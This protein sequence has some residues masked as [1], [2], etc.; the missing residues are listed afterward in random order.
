M[1]LAGVG[2]KTVRGKREREPA[3]LTQAQARTQIRAWQPNAARTSTEG[4]VNSRLGVALHLLRSTDW[5][6]S[7]SNPHL[8]YYV[9]LA[10]HSV[11]EVSALKQ[12]IRT[13][14]WCGTGEVDLTKKASH[15]RVRGN[16]KRDVSLEVAC[17][18]LCCNRLHT[19]AATCTSQDV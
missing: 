18:A 10:K 14:I 12:P 11:V 19:A 1:T 4:D 3:P 17:E 15:P 6:I 7:L 13:R 16:L 9:A 2:R 5:M 8:L